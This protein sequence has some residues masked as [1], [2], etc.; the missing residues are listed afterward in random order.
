MFAFAS[1]RQQARDPAMVIWPTFKATEGGFS[2]KHRQLVLE[3][4]DSLIAAYP[5]D[6]DRIYL[7]G[8]SCAASEA[9]DTLALRPGFFAGALF[10]D[11]GRG[12]ARPSAVGRVPSWIFG[13]AGSFVGGTADLAHS[14]RREGGFALFTR[15]D[16]PDHIEA[17]RAG[18]SNPAAVTWLLA[19]RLGQ[20]P[21][22]PFA[23]VIEQPTSEPNLTT[24]ATSLNLSGSA[25]S[26]EGRLIRVIWENQTGKTAGLANGSYDWPASPVSLVADKTNVIAVTA[27]LDTT[28]AP[29]F[30]GTTTFGDTISVFSTPV[31]L[32][33]GM[34][35]NDAT[36]DWTGGVPPFTVQRA[37]TI[38]AAAWE[39]TLSNVTP[40]VRVSAA[41]PTQFHRVRGR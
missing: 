10:W 14:L 31:R 23:L 28:W 25:R 3:L 38:D 1:Y 17:I 7:G 33:L 34:H 19:Q 36:L 41:G 24:A 20:E 37:P 40:P 15:Y 13:S 4:L 5:V 16:K 11:G 27:T 21:T 29:A 22:S 2:P 8:V 26:S 30:G 6:T 12:T 35:G 32:S 9:W 39:D 18:L